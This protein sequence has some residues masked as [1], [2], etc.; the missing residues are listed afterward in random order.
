MRAFGS[1]GR[2]QSELVMGCVYQWVGLG[3]V[4]LGQ[5]FLI[6]CGLGWVET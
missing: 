1:A 2:L 6:L 4:E 3:W 5:R